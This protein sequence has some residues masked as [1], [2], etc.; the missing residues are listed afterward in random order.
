MPDERIVVT[1]EGHTLIRFDRS[2]G[3]WLMEAKSLRNLAGLATAANVAAAIVAGG[4]WI[5]VR[6][7]QRR[8]A[9]AGR[10]TESSQSQ[11]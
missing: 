7:R 4:I 1:P 10:A 6:R 9:A 2:Q 11:M 5:V 8:S 3:E